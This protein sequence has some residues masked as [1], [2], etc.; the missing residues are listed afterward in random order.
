MK[1][2]KNNLSSTAILT[3]SVA[4]TDPNLA[5]NSERRN[6]QDSSKAHRRTAMCVILYVCEPVEVAAGA[7]SE[8]KARP[9]EPKFDCVRAARLSPTVGPMPPLL[10]PKN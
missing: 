5:L 10:Q 9:T 1:L 2:K 7:T 8:A 4:H 3:R 6:C